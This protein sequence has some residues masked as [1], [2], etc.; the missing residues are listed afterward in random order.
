MREV[1]KSAYKSV[2]LKLKD[3][4]NNDAG[5]SAQHQIDEAI[6]ISGTTKN[7]SAIITESKK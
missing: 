5:M 7:G 2:Q 6:T 3:L 1:T 4:E